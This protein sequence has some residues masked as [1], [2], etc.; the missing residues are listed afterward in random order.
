MKSPFAIMGRLAFPLVLGS[1]LLAAP[2][3]KAELWTNAAGHAIEAEFIKLDGNAAVFKKQD[4][5]RVTLSLASLSPGARTQVLESAGKIII[6]E[7]F[8]SEFGL[9]ARTL[10]RLTEL[11]GA[12]ELPEADYAAQ[13]EAALARLK[14][15]L[16][17]SGV[18]EPDKA[19]LLMLARNH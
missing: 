6:P 5:T 15:I 1:C 12:G 14:K 18:P 4:G 16:E 10:Q 8:R 11:Q 7:A 3:A 19:R 9:C 13:R 17:Q 2:R